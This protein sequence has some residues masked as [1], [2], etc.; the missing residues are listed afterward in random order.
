[1]SIYPNVTGLLIVSF[2]LKVGQE[3][4]RQDHNLLPTLQKALKSDSWQFE[5]G[6][7]N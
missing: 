5:E 7:S 1:M 6:L 3:I 4:T 2:Y